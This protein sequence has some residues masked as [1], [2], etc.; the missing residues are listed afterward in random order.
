M[1]TKM[2]Y[3]LTFQWGKMA[4]PTQKFWEIND[5]YEWLLVSPS[6]LGTENKDKV[7]KEVLKL[8]GGKGFKNVP[9][10][11]YLV[12][13]IPSYLYR[14]LVSTVDVAHTREGR[15]NLLSYLKQGSDVALV[16]DRKKLEKLLEK[17]PE[18]EE[19]FR[20]RR[21]WNKEVIH[22]QMEYWPQTISAAYL[23]STDKWKDLKKIPEDCKSC[24][25]PLNT[26][27]P[28]G[29]CLECREVPAHIKKFLAKKKVKPEMGV[30]EC[31]KHFKSFGKDYDWNYQEY[32][33]LRDDYE[34]EDDEDDDSDSDW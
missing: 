28:S 10:H 24:G 11:K 34:D 27:T 30:E 8:L 31:M 33:E 26:L 29:R 15:I 6:A 21:W 19:V 3:L 16:L 17:K 2:W 7:V 4:L 20:K 14:T 32:H 18:M 13:F 22:Y 5:H 23:N 9:T 25:Y 1:F 12:E